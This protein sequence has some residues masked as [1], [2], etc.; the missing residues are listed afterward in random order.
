MVLNL[1]FFML[2]NP[3]PDREEKIIR[4]VFGASAGIV[5]GGIVFYQLQWGPHLLVA[6]LLALFLGAGAVRFGDD[7]WCGC[8][9]TKEWLED[10]PLVR[11]ICAFLCGLIGS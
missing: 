9:K 3:K 2:G 7:F 10:R 6:S 5:I 1:A 11:L 8:S 4:F